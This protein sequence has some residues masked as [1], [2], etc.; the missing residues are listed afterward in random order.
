MVRQ[1]KV[2]VSVSAGHKAVASF[3][4]D[5]AGSPDYLNTGTGI[6]GR[7]WSYIVILGRG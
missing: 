5:W 3:A 4:D 6:H 2:V 7:G 1:K